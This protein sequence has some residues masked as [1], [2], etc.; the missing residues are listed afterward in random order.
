VLARSCSAA[1]LEQVERARARMPA[2]R[3][4][5][6]AGELVAG[7]LDWL[8]RQAGGGPVLIYSSAPPEERAAGA[9]ELVEDAIGTLARELVDR[10]VRRLIVAGGETSAAVLDS[11]GVSACTLGAEEAVGV[12]WLFPTGRTDLALLLKSG[13]FGDPDLLVRAAER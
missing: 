12:P 11:I 6:R 3:L 4:D 9:A 5:P 8:D 10:G 13:N 7:C 2:H 1:T